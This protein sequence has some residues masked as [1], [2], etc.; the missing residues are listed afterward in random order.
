MHRHSLAL[1]V[2][3]S[4]MNC[5]LVWLRN[6]WSNWSTQLGHSKGCI[7]NWFDL[8][9]DRNERIF[10]QTNH[11]LSNMAQGGDLSQA[12]IKKLLE[13]LSKQIYK[14]DLKIGSFIKKDDKK[15]ILKFEIQ[16]E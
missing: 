6:Y 12:H 10:P 15:D 8:K 5:K 7:F 2:Q 11:L 3:V 9:S 4:G 1:L 14:I 13:S 16:M